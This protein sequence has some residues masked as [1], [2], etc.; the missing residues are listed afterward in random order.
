[1][2]IPTLLLSTFVS[3]LPP[4]FRRCGGQ[5]TEAHGAPQGNCCF[6][7]SGESSWEPFGRLCSWC[8]CSIPS[9]LFLFVLIDWTLY[10]HTA[11]CFPDKPCYSICQADSCKTM[12]QTPVFVSGHY[13]DTCLTCLTASVILWV[14]C[15][16]GSGQSGQNV[17]VKEKYKS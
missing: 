2:F 12:R 14:S 13:F 5:M 8:G 3:L 11:L 7:G 6:C 10:T 9:Q 1:M 16:S 4:S 17:K 15:E